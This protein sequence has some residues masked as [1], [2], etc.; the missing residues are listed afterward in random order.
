[1]AEIDLGKVVGPQGEPGAKGD[2][3]KE[4]P[5]GPPGPE[6]VVDG[7]STITFVTPEAY[8]EPQSG[9]SIAN[10]FGRFKRWILDIVEKIGDLTSL[11]TPDKKS[12]VAAINANYDSIAQLEQDIGNPA[13][14]TTTSKEVVGAVNELNAD[15]DSTKTEVGR[16]ANSDE[17]A[18]TN[19]LLKDYLITREFSVQYNIP[20]N[21]TANYA[22][23][24]PVVSGYKLL[25]CFCNITNTGQVTCHYCDTNRVYF[26]NHAA[27]AKSA[28]AILRAIYI[29]N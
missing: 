2:T 27:N 6:G 19:N 26:W 20:G 8:Q 24:P 12:A 14:L 5:Q 17:L 23:N 21:S 3:G 18:K 11:K 15:L 1:M 10:L 16:K 25:Y 29:R 7:N 22:V 9:D 4:G 28:I 13:D